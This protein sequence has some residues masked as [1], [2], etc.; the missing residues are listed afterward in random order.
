MPLGLKRG[1]VELK[2]YNLE[3]A[4]LFEEEKIALQSILGNEALGIKHVGS[5]AIP[6]MVAKPIL[7]LMVAVESIDSFDRFTPKLEQLG[8]QFM[9]DERDGLEH[10][11]YIKGPEEK[12]THYLKLTT[13]DSEFWKDHILF[14]DYLIN[15]LDR[16]KQYKELKQ[17]LLEKHADKRENYTKE[18]SDFI[19]E[20]LQL[21]QED[22]NDSI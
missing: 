19:V 13:L 17:E 1:T 22:K 18:K 7:D 3:W 11:L 20:T 2:S 6:G 16:A 4:R 8:Y 14:R 21:A 12:R 10:I 15:H 5:T 9:R